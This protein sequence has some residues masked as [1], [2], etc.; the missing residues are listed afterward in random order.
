MRKH[1][2]FMQ[3]FDELPQTLPI[4]PLNGA[5]L[6]PRG[7]LPLNIFEPRYLNM[8]RDAMGADQLIGMIQVPQEDNTDRLFDVGCAG[9]ITRYEET[10]DGRLEIVLTGACRFKIIAELTS[11][12][13]YRLVTPDWSDFALDYQDQAEPDSQ[14]TMLFKAALRNYFRSNKL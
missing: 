4:F 3:A 11:V 1:L 6:L 10:D 12:R 14:S 13:G 9:R 8:L 2:P 5:V 7:N